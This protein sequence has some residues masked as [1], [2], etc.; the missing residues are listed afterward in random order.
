M[1]TVREKPHRLKRIRYQGLV[2]VAF[3]VCLEQRAPLFLRADTVDL[4]VEYLKCACEEANVHAVYCFMPEHVHTISIGQSDGSD[5]LRWIENFKHMTGWWLK[6]HRPNIRW[7]KGFWDRITRSTHEEAHCA[8]YL[9]NNPVRRGL[10][11]T[12]DDYPFTGSIGFD[13]KEYLTDLLPFT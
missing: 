4:F 13:L 2:S 5:A 9:V 10:V 3:T 6:T 8:W 12:W 1:K 11:E 7:Q